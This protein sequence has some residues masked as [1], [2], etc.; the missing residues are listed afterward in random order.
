MPKSIQHNKNRSKIRNSS[1]LLIA[2]LIVFLLLYNAGVQTNYEHKVRE[3]ENKVVTLDEELKLAQEEILIFLQ[4]SDFTETLKMFNDS[5]QDL[6]ELVN[7]I[8]GITSDM[9]E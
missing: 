9:G 7:R 2:L 4:G 6:G 1:T 5:Q 8:K 3:L